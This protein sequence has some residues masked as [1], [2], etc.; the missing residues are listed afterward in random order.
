MEDPEIFIDSEDPDLYEP[1]KKWPDVPV[2]KKVSSSGAPAAVAGSSRDLATDP[3]PCPAA[4]SRDLMQH[5]VEVHHM[6]VRALLSVGVDPCKEYAKAQALYVLERVKIGHTRCSLC[7]RQCHSTQKLREHIKA[8][9]MATTEHQ[10]SI[11]NKSFGSG[12]F[13]K[14]HNRSH[15]EKV[16]VCHVC[17]RG[18]DTQSHLDTHSKDH[19]GLKFTCTY[20]SKSFAQERSLKSHRK[21][22][23]SQ[24][25]GP[26]PKVVCK[27]C[28]RGFTY[29]K[30]LKKHNREKY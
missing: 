13:L 2:P 5:M 19:L 10:C 21:M 29:P 30:D 11:C 26:P 22:C 28:G 8:K 23:K 7:D 14:L 3:V 15:R 17:Q 4:P 18:F 12:Y 25:G 20:C 6:Q 24:P 1:R 27:K 9:H 16:F